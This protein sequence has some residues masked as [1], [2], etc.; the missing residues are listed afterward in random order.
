M[1]YHM[2]A[3]GGGRGTW[4]GGGGYKSLSLCI[5]WKKSLA[6]LKEAKTGGER[7]SA[8]AQLEKGWSER[9]REIATAPS[10]TH[11]MSS[12][13]D[14]PSPLLHFLH[15]TWLRRGG[16]HVHSDSVAVCTRWHR[17]GGC[18][19]RFTLVLHVADFDIR[20]LPQHARQVADLYYCFITLSLHCN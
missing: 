18:M 19:S 10:T 7:A 4:E 6:G 17:R 15:F 3:R 9:R 1:V 8:D 14:L 13:C 20:S 12:L 5:H 16:G 2:M 11:S